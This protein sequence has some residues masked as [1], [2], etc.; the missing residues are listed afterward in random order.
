[1]PGSQ[2]D[3]TDAPLEKLAGRLTDPFRGFI[4]AQSASGWVLLSATFVAMLL[5]NSFAAADYFELTQL[6]FG[7]TLGEFSLS[8]SLQHWV[9][10]GLMALFFFLLGLELK[11]E[12]LVGKLSGLKRASAPLFAAAGGMAL[13]AGLF[14][15][16][17]DSE[18]I[19]N[20]WAIPVATDTAFAITLLKL[21][22]K[23]VPTSAR[24]F[25][26]GL[27]IID[28][29]GAIMVIA[30]AYTSDFN[31]AFVLPTLV[32]LAVLVTLN[33]A[34]VR[35][36]LPYLLVGV[37]LWFLFLKM[38]LHGTLTGVVVALAAPV[39]PQIARTTFL[40]ALKEKLWHFEDTHDAET[41]NV[42]QQPEQQLI[43]HDI[44]RVAE[45]ANVPLSRW[46]SRLEQPIS[47][48]VMPLFAL[49]NAGLAIST[50]S[51]NATTSSDLGLAIA[52]GLLIGKPGGILGG[53][54]LGARFGW[55]EL[56]QGLSWRH[57]LG[58]GLLGSIGFTMSL[59]I[60]H[61]SFDSAEEL[62][63]IAKLSVIVTSFVG[64]LLGYSWLRWACP[65]RT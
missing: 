51:L 57:I 13:P 22:G 25:L 9:N 48:I 40:T 16:V 5:A 34:G 15:F 17:A 38:G 32:T 11:R 53:M 18:V 43:A 31:S 41:D 59:F 55:V 23:Q 10:D 29:L 49:M 1:M 47:F 58:L 2:P 54:W 3:L 45:K 24:A 62:L 4:R 61:L 63:E 36:G 65:A 42:F 27:A 20:G 50:Q 12:F 14:L 39:R 64:G 35:R 26:V 6:E 37:V 56:P 30:I 52:L 8:M 21:L 46:E 33:L 60:G 28:D 44:A 7:L 19:R